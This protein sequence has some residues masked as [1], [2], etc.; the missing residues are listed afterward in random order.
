MF[1]KDADSPLVTETKRQAAYEIYKNT[2]EP[3]QRDRLTCEDF[4]EAIRKYRLIPP[5]EI[6]GPAMRRREIEVAKNIRR[7][8]EIEGQ[9]IP[10]VI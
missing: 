7:D 4:I 8:L 2:C 3:R 6:I 10:D 5:I 9:E 1:L